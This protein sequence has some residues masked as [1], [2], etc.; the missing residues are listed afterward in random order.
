MKISL[1]TSMLIF[2]ISVLTNA[3]NTTL[4]ESQNGYRDFKLG[5]TSEEVN[6]LHIFG[7][8]PKSQQY[9]ASEYQNPDATYLAYWDLV[10]YG[11]FK[12]NGYAYYMD[13][14]Y[15]C[16][17]LMFYKNRLFKI[18][19][20]FWEKYPDENARA[21]ENTNKYYNVSTTLKDGNKYGQLVSESVKYE[22]FSDGTTTKI[23]FEKKFVENLIAANLP[24][25]DFNLSRFK[26]PKIYALVIGINDYSR[27]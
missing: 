10:N 7:I 2:L 22:G 14:P 4:L 13:S 11:G 24:Y 23:S 17:I 20:Q 5:M 16:I 8:P 3:Q 21:L 27:F 19:I 26:R 9:L 15:K 25:D 18:S 1:V 12:Q 6:S